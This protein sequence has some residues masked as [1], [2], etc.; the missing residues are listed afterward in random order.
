[1]LETAVAL[2]L[3]HVLADF[4]LQTNAMVRDKTRPSV[5]ALHIAIVALASWLMLGVPPEPALIALIAGSHAAIDAAKLRWGGVGFR[6]FALDQ[7]GHLVMIAL[8]SALFPGAWAGGLWAGADLATVPGIDRL[9]EVMALAAGLI[10]TVPAGGY[11]VQALMTAVPAPKYPSSL[12]RGGRLIGRLERLA[13]LM[14]V[15]AEEP[16]AIGF[17]V[18]AKSILR[19]NEIARD[20]DRHTSEYVIIGTLASFAWAIAAAFLTRGALAALRAT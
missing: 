2:V 4:V 13:I 3:A 20:R 11:A 5:L 15:L 18:A 10:A 12:P 8:A 19:F 14:L 16:A 7:S 6:G 17:L 9:P 1:M